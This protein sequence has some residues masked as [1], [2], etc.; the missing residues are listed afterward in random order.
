MYSYVGIYLYSFIHGDSLALF[1]QQHGL[2]HTDVTRYEYYGTVARAVADADVIRTNIR[3]KSNP[4]RA[5][6]FYAAYWEERRRYYCIGVQNVT[7]FP[8]HFDLDH[9][10]F[11]EEK[12]MKA[13]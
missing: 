1:W 6:D 4:P 11:P 10:V 7:V 2:T 3:K 12:R 13:N 5:F 9:R 8:L